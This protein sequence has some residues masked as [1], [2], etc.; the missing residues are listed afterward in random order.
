MARPI[1]RDEPVTIAAAPWLIGHVSRFVVCS[2]FP[3]SIMNGPCAANIPALP[4]KSGVR[5]HT[6]SARC[7]LAPEW[8]K[9]LR[10]SVLSLIVKHPPRRLTQKSP[11]QQA[12]RSN[13]GG[14]V[15]SSSRKADADDET[16]NVL[17]SARSTLPRPSGHRLP[18][19]VAHVPCWESPALC[20]RPQRRSTA[21]RSS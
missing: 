7:S 17:S 9:P 12:Y 20:Q 4:K 16:S 14:R 10:C 3:P 13:P 11:D 2:A 15:A 21:A 18:Q 6:D 1:P 19:H 5:C 8:P